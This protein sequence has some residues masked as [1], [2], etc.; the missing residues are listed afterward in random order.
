MYVFRRTKH[1]K[2]LIEMTP[3]EY[4]KAVATE[5]SAPLDAEN[6][7]THQQVTPNQARQWVKNGGHHETGLWVDDGKVRYARADPDG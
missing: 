2:T 1:T 6:R 4:R 7:V 5:H 3:A